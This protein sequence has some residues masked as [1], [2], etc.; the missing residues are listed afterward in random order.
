[1]IIETLIVLIVVVMWELLKVN[2][3]IKKGVRLRR[4]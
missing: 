1:M 4:Q 2:R 3:K